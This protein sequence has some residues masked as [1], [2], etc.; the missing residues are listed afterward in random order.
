MLFVNTALLSYR[1]NEKIEVAIGR[2]QLPTGINIAD[3]AVFIRSRNRLGYYDTPTQVKAYLGSSRYLLT[4]Y[5]FGPGGNEAPGL[6]E[7]GGGVLA[8]F[9]VLGKRKT[10]AGINLVRGV[11]SSGD[12]LMVGP[13]ARLGFGRWGIL[14][15]H[16]ITSRSTKTETP[17]S[18]RQAASYGQ[19]FWAARE[20][21]VP[22]L[23]F[24]RLRIDRPY[25]ENLRAVKVEVSAR[26]S[27]QFTVSVGP[28]LQHDQLTGRTTK[29]VVFQVAMKTVR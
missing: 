4:P 10:I 26:I 12:R 16:D 21:L 25:Q 3:L 1:A 13:Y 15:E 17:I 18:F 6:R 14:A 11:A 9:D 7:S 5:A 28:R 2:D 27:P 23:I 8:E 22:S 29:S 20:W 19:L 24:E